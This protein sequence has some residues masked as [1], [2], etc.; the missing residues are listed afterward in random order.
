MCRCRWWLVEGVG[1]QSIIVQCTKLIPKVVL[2]S[3]IVILFYES[4]F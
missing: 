1:E 4:E 3:L 2:S